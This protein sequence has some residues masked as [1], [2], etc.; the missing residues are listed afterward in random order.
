MGVENDILWSET[1]GSGFKE[2]GSTTPLRIPRSIPGMVVET[3]H[4]LEQR[5]LLY[6]RFGKYREEED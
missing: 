5:C 3:F 6:P 1:V 4:E 2:L